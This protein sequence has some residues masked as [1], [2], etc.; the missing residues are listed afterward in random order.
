MG[1]SRDFCTK[2]MHWEVEDE[3]KKGAVKD[4]RCII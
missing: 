1:G 2:F 4:N 3:T